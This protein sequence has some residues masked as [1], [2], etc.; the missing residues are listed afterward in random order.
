MFENKEKIKGKIGASCTKRF[1]RFLEIHGSHISWISWL[2]LVL[3]FSWF[4][5]VA[6]VPLYL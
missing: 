5:N 4:L 1:S 6:R 2:S 3:W